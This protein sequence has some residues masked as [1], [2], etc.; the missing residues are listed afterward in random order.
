MRQFGTLAAAD[1]ADLTD[2]R[3]PYGEVAIF[4]RHADTVLYVESRVRPGEHAL[5]SLD[6]HSMV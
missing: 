1:F 2:L 6:V 4:G 5:R 3:R